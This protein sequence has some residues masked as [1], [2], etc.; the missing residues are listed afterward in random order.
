MLTI[1]L[2]YFQVLQEFPTDWLTAFS[3]SLLSASTVSFYSQSSLSTL[4][5]ENQEEI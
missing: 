3:S 2:V 1:V 4:G 5:F